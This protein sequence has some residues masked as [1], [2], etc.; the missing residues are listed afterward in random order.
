M[1][2][3]QSLLGGTKTRNPPSGE[4]R[5]VSPDAWERGAC[6]VVV[7]DQLVGVSGRA[8]AG[9]HGADRGIRSQAPHGVRV[10]SIG[11]EVVHSPMAVRAVSILPGLC[12]GAA[13]PEREPAS[14]HTSELLAGARSK[15]NGLGVS[16]RNGQS[17]CMTS[18]ETVPVPYNAPRPTGA[19]ARGCDDG[20]VAAGPL[21]RIIDRIDPAACAG[22]DERTFTLATSDPPSARGSGT[23]PSGSVGS[24]ANGPLPSTEP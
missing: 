2:V 12:P 7:V 4:H 14:A 1:L 13:D 21:P 17:G 5:T 10:Q 9:T 22:R 24:V 11:V 18:S 16:D 3:S 23:G 19:R 20:A 8:A 6:D 15:V